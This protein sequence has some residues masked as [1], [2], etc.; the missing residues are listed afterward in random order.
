MDIPADPM[1]PA[2]LF[3]VRRKRPGA[4]LAAMLLGGTAIAHA[5]TTAGVPTET[6]TTKTKPAPK[7]AGRTAQP[8]SAT[9]AA[10]EQV[11]VTARRHY[12]AEHT[13]VATKTSAP[14]LTTPQSISVITHDQLELRSVQTIDQ[15][16]QY[17]AGVVSGSYGPDSHLDYITVRGFTP[18]EYLDGIQLPTAAVI[19]AT[20]RPEVYGLQQID[21]LKGP[22]SALYGQTPPG[23]LIAMVSKRP[24]ATPVGEVQ[25]QYGSFASKQ[26]AFDL[27]GPLDDSGTLLYRVTGL[28]RNNG[29][30]VDYDNARREF[31]AP[32]L[33]WR[34][35]PDA[36]LTLLGEYQ[37]DHDHT[38]VQDLPSQ[39]TVLPNPHGKLSSS[40]YVGDPNFDTYRREAYNFGYDFNYRIDDNLTFHQN[41]KY[42]QNFSDYYTIYGQGLQ[43]DLRT[44]TRYTYT[45][46]GAPSSTGA[47]T[48]LEGRYETGAIHHDILLG[49]DF[50]HS[51]DNTALG[52][53]NGPTI[54]VFDPVY[55]VPI[56]RPPVAS[57]IVLDQNQTGIYL[58]DQASY[59]HL[60]LTGS[61]R[62]DFVQSDQH[63][64]IASTFSATSDRA[65]SG[66]VGL[67]YLLPAGF[68]PYAQ[69]SHSFQPTL[70]YSFSGTPFTP[71][72]ANA[73]EVGLKY[74]PPSTNIFTTL[75]AY[76]L[77]EDNALTPDPDPAHSGFQVQT[78]QIRVRGVELETIARL[79]D[80]FS[81]NGAYSYTDARYT[82]ANDASLGKQVLLVAP[83]QFSI[84]GDYTWPTGQLAGL[85]LGVG[86]RYVGFN[87][88]D[89][90]NEIK[91]PAYTLT[92]MILHYDIKHWHLAVN[93]NNLFD[94]T[95]I[96]TCYSYDSCNFGSRRT[97]YLTAAYRW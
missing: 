9:G 85:G 70:G 86:V 54:D 20:A 6:V 11:T 3:A 2:P 1:P 95:Y 41:V 13:D 15:A 72:T 25:L 34:I 93:A 69:F 79:G 57:Q 24:T 75:S 94:R 17:S 78:G 62:Y 47:D 58:Q 64:L 96:A 65:P 38:T 40:L 16:V 87:Y 63:D 29:T 88:G 89:P 50:R 23:G 44:L 5:Q 33:E 31:I 82:K 83:N 73:Y 66:R 81:L 92:D 32:S 19:D 7:P 74:K 55:N 59:R 36:S 52:F 39:G 97:V 43:S 84:L 61:V 68:A 71:T 22:A 18:T 26:A 77:T 42:F 56:V 45:V 91:T 76:S 21:I 46:A 90:T 48:H 49:V 30:Q 27:G 28:Y 35:S 10:A 12:V 14:L 53:G 37:N 60:F 8:S 51:F 80:N 4:A 67:S